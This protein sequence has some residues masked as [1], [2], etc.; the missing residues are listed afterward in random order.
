MRAA[1]HTLG[2]KV[3]QYETEALTEQFRA[4]G[5]SITGEDT[6][7]DVYVINTCTVTGLADRKSRQFMRRARK[8]NPAAVVAVTGCY[9]QIAS[10]DI[11]AL[12]EV[13]LVVGTNEK[14]NLLGY[15]MTLLKE[16]A[17]KADAPLQAEACAADAAAQ[18]VRGAAGAAVQHVH[19][20]A[21][22]DVYEE[23]PLAHGLGSRTRA[24]I[25]I[26]EGCDR[27]CSYCVIP[28]AR[29]PVRSRRR[30]AV[31]EEARRLVEAGYHELIL[32]GINTALY[33]DLPGLL[34]LL[35]DLPGDFRIR[36]SSLEPTVV[37]AAFVKKLFP[38][39]RL[40]HHLHLSM[41]SGSD[42]VLALMNRRYRREDYFAIVDT[43]RSFDPQYGITT[44]LIA[45]FPG[46]T[47]Q[48]LEDSLEAIRRCRFGKV[49]AFRYSERPGTRAST[50]DGRI[51]PAVRKERVRLL[52]AQGEETAADFFRAQIGTV[53]QVL[54]ESGGEEEDGHLS[55]DKP[56]GTAGASAM[57]PLMSG[58][59]GNYIKVYHPRQEAKINTFSRVEI[60][61]LCRDGLCG[62]IL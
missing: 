48:D 12:P 50:M 55:A 49:H 21:A 28:Y 46:E 17:R 1:F 42:R 40:C 56:G 5:F 23:M 57:Q 19:D 33:E 38:F 2:C 27:F 13:D 9:A 44:D 11:A 29:G 61:G 24:Y 62:R 54:F 47:K 59:T 58:Y 41:Q 14:H 35:E 25:K 31:L 43:L 53:Q 20:R 37:D 52:A 60:T 6:F 30:D 36:L 4:V 26:E 3:N 7:A 39:E 15:I 45:G 22:L 32:T 51:D 10:E 16:R 34:G 18:S 8:L